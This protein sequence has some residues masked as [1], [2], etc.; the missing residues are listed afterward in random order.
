MDNDKFN[1]LEHIQ[2]KPDSKLKKFKEIIF[3]LG[4]VVLILILAVLFLWKDRANIVRSSDQKIR[5]FY[6]SLADSEI[7]FTDSD[8]FV[9]PIDKKF[10][11]EVNTHVANKESF[12]EVDLSK[13]EVSLYKEGE[14]FKKLNVLSK[15][16]DGS[17]W[18]TPTGNYKILSKE[19][20]HYSSIGNVWMPWS[21][22]FYG[23][24][25]IHG[26]PYYEDGRQVS[27]S[28]S[29]GCVRMSTADAKEVYKFAEK[30]M[31]VLLRDKEDETDFAKPITS[32]KEI[33][34]PKVSAKAFLISDLA[35]GETIL[36]KN[37][38][39]VVPI[40]SL[41]KIMT[42]IVASELVYL[43]K[44]ITVDKSM[45]ASA[46]A[47]FEPAPGQRYVAFDLLYPLLMQSSN[48]AA[49]ILAGFT[50]K[51][52]FIA[53]M[54]KKAA[55]LSMYDTNFADASGE[56]AANTSS[57]EDL[58][59][60][61]RYTLFKRKF[62][63]DISKGKQ[64]YRFEGRKLDNLKNYNELIDVNNLVGIKNGE[65]TAAGQT[66]AGVWEFN[67][68]NGKVPVGIIVLGSTDRAKDTEN[69]LNW[70]KQSFNL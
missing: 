12:I 65:T 45:L 68:P 7:G 32:G 19:Q 29:G 62:L 36:E 3:I 35:T 18:E 21:M 20:N 28:Y 63:F 64:D 14:L 46:F 44:P 10:E 16:K 51:D 53:N 37:S 9:L 67:T 15:G 69:L 5:Q 1:I 56:L 54:N 59:K 49:N 55:S 27:N 13:M 8:E 4:S 48:Q 39:S 26:W 24:F 25:F 66:L 43:G 58:K 33:P 41:T 47:S 52:Q 23:N 60:L 31:T 40:A 38:S 61:L 70:L 50:G 6:V 2:G 22:Q 42:G 11:D 17:W 57:A 30:G 34:P